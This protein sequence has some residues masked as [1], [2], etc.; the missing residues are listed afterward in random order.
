M[1]LVW[2]PIPT[3]VVFAPLIWWQAQRGNVWALLADPGLVWDGPQLGA[4]A[5]GR[6]LLATGFPS[7]DLAGWT[8]LIGDQAVWAPLLLAPVAV[9]ALA[10]AVSPRW[11]VGIALLVVTATGLA[12][13]FLAVGVF[14]AFV[15]GAP[16]AI[17][18][19]T[20]LSLAWIGLAGAAL[21]TLDT[22][23]PL[24]QLR[25]LAALVAG[26]AVIACAAPALTALARDATHLTNGP[27]STL[28]AYVAAD[29]RGDL[30]RA[31]LVLTPL[32]ANEL[33]ARTVWGSSETLGA[34]TTMVTTA[35][36]PVGTDIS[37]L[38]VALVSPRAF[39]VAEEL[40]EHGI[41][42]VLVSEGA[43]ESAGAR[44]LRLA[45][46]SALNQRAGLVKVGET[47]KG[48]LWRTAGDTGETTLT[49]GQE[50]MAGQIFGVT[51]AVLL[52]GLLLALP[53]RASRRAARSR[54]RVVGATGEER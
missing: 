21:V 35:T 49:A 7:P 27:I 22:A 34:Q 31:T 23:L 51:F 17:W 18:P 15:Q 9:L 36:R 38:A 33:S 53:T 48:T 13:A 24:R 42:Y 47:D 54:S 4:D 46:I 6:G 37:E 5:A 12:T 45:A 1:R 40:S 2:V 16:V 44:E 8:G 30:P 25:A 39:E 26:L 3:A 41:R 14:V 43:E 29:A 50:R 19:G 20:G 11:R 32:G 52:A 10:A 28:P